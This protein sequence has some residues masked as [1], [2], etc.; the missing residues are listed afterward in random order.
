V[1]LRCPRCKNALPA[2]EGVQVEA[3]PAQVAFVGSL[4]PI[5][6]TALGAGD[7]MLTCP[8]CQQL[9]HQECWRE[10]G[11]C[12]TYGCEKAPAP[13]SEGAPP[14]KPASAWGDT[15]ICPDCGETIKAISLRCRYCRARFDT[16]DPI[17]RGDW[18]R[19]QR[20]ERDVQGLRSTITVLFVMALIGILAPIT[21][22]LSLALLLPRRELLPRAGP[23][24]R[25]LAYSTIGLSALY[26]LLMVLFLVAS[27]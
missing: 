1:A 24:Y 15:K 10:V 2:A 7:A 23:L 18:R 26:S 11:G 3:A 13:A 9:H 16:V 17:S 27:K 12:G 20:R 14:R 6:Q 5:C 4:C 19:H 22:L 25:I 8:S 21:L